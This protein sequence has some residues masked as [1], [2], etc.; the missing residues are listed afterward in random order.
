MPN[1]P[2]FERYL[3]KDNLSRIECLHG[4]WQSDRPHCQEATCIHPNV[5]GFNGYV[6]NG[7]STFLSGEGTSLTCNSTTRFDLIPKVDYLLCDNHGQWKPTL[8]RCYGKKSTSFNRDEI[9]G[10]ISLLAKCRL[11]DLGTNLIGYYMDDNTNEWYGKELQAGAFIR[12]GYTIKYQC[13]CPAKYSPNCSL[14]QPVSTQCLDGQWTNDGP[15]CRE[16]LFQMIISDLIVLFFKELADKC[17]IPS[18]IP[19]ILSNNNTKIGLYD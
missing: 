16:G 19:H 1:T 10:I 3:L 17:L 6:L 7:R 12:H 8:P 18:D 5:L 14:M 2:C 13:Q 15:Q 9:F 4:R 11:P